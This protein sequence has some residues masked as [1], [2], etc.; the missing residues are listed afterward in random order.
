VRKR[1]AWIWNITLGLAAV[2][3]G[4]FVLFDVL[5]VD[6]SQLRAPSTESVL[7]EDASVIIGRS[8]IVQPIPDA[9]GVSLLP[10]S[11]STAV[12]APRLS[13]LLR[14]THP[15][16]S[17]TLARARLT[18]TSASGSGSAADPV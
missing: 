18:L 3:I 10:P 11:Q 12:D 14:R 6:G 7:T 9:F 17:T 16:R 1:R 13:T 2:A 5:D 15:P 8:C 4:A